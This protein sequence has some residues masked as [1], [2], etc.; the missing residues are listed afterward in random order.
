M[1]RLVALA[2][3]V[4][5]CASSVFAWDSDSFISDSDDYYNFQSVMLMSPSSAFALS[6]SSPSTST[7]NLLVDSSWTVD[8]SVT[9][10]CTAEVAGVSYIHPYTEDL[11]YNTSI[12]GGW[13]RIYFSS[14]T[15]TSEYIG[16]LSKY[17]WYFP[18]NSFI[19]Y[20]Y[21]ITGNPTAI[22]L[23]W[24]FKTVLTFYF[25]GKN[26]GDCFKPSHIDVLINGSKVDTWYPGTSTYFS[27][28]S[29]YTDYSG[30]KTLTLSFSYPSK[31]FT[32]SSSSSTFRWSLTSGFSGSGSFIK[33]GIL[34][35]NSSLNGFNNDAQQSIN[36]HEAIESQW[37]GSM[38]SN[39]DALDP[40]SFTY[41]GGLISG[42]SLITGIFN[43]LWNGMGEFKILYV[44][45]LTLG[46]MLLVIGKLS[47]FAGHGSSAR[48]SG[49]DGA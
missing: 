17:T 1:K 45:P 44:F 15:F 28:S 20:N 5:C 19:N 40:E 4:L 34:S 26:Q 21:S 22:S 36:D 43:D 13:Q 33:L 23:D 38:T 30:I 49:D 8:G 14:N 47:K 48:K 18:Y 25:N 16:D 39:F 6:D 37:T 12:H 42:F 2:V 3:A 32:G 24:Y 41:P 35:D 9:V 7:D 10:G 46:I 27:G 11:F 29:I 31:T